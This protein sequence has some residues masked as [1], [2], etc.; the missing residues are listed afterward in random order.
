MPKNT[1]REAANWNFDGEEIT[2][3]YELS[4]MEE[5]E[6]NEEFESFAKKVP[7]AD[8]EKFIVARVASKLAEERLENKQRIA[9]IVS[10]PENRNPLHAYLTEKPNCDDMLG[11]Q[12]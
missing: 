2:S 5:A 10:A 7:F 8:K 12:I 9:S 4:P 6:L 3:S 1:R 11:Y